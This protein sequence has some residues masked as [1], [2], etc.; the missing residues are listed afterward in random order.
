MGIKIKP[1]KGLNTVVPILTY[2]RLNDE[3]NYRCFL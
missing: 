1:F 3:K 2:Q